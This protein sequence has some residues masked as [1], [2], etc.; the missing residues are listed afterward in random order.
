MKKGFTLVEL[1]LY[2]GILAL[3]LLVQTQILTSVLSVQLE[4][5]A[6]TSVSW[7]ARFIMARLIYDINRAE[8]IVT[9]ATPSAQTNSLTLTINGISN[10]Y[11]L[12]GG[13][14]LISNN[15]GPDNLNSD[16]TS[17]SNLSFKR[18][19][20]TGG[21]NTVTFSL[22]ITS[23]TQREHGPE[24]RTIQATAGLR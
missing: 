2:M 6:N 20:N 19:G 24:S 10:T 3:L 7:D 22:T 5:E 18:L 13:N 9:P 12:S 15:L 11:S 14:L 8:N 17:I 21:K 1:L 4:S 23:I 16:A